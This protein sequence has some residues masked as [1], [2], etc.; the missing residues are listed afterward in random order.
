[1]TTDRSTEESPTARRNL[2]ARLTHRPRLIVDVWLNDDIHVGEDRSILSAKALHD[3]CNGW[4]E[5]SLGLIRERWRLR[6]S[7]AKAHLSHNS[8]AYGTAFSHLGIR[9][10]SLDSVIIKEKLEANAS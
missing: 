3:R 10:R 4:H 6:K 7:E 2:R 5:A 9:E 1:M 8:D